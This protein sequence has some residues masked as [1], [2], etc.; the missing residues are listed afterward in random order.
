[1]NKKPLKIV[2]VVRTMRFAPSTPVDAQFYLPAAITRPDTAP[3]GTIT[4]ICV[5]ESTVNEEVLTP[6]NATVLAPVKLSPRIVTG[7]QPVETS[8]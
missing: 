1:M 3:S 7:C 6:P 8:W 2:G 5:S 4:E